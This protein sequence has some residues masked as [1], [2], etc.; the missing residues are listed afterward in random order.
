MRSRPT[1]WKPSRPNS[2]YAASIRICRVLLAIAAA[3]PA[4]SAAPQIL[5]RQPRDCK[6]AFDAAAIAGT[7][8]TM[9]RVCA[10]LIVAAG[11]SGCQVPEP[12]A[13][14]ASADK[15]DAAMVEPLG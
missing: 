13:G 8:P 3:H 4:A 12:T 15:H 5:T 7:L 6:G 9:K 10:A 2:S 11:M 1:V 14:P